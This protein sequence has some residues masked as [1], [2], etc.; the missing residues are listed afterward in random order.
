M[1]FSCT[2]VTVLRVGTLPD[3]SLLLAGVIDNTGFPGGAS[4]KEPACQCK[5]HKRCRFDPSVGKSS[6]GGHGNPLQNSCMQKP[7]DRGAWQAMSMGLQRIGHDLTTK[8]HKHILY[9]HT[10]YIIKVYMYI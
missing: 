1:H 5:K 7:V 10:I 3:K 8:H 6:E 9:T 2:S 4:G